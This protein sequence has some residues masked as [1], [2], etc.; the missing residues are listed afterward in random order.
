[1]VN[2]KV[3]AV[4]VVVVATVV[5]VAPAPDAHAQLRQPRLVVQIRLEPHH[6]VHPHE[7]KCWL[8]TQACSAAFRG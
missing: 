7:R 3:A 6:E 1:M 8:H 4:V 5:V 2:D